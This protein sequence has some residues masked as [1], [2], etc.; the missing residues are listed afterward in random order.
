MYHS[1]EWWQISG[2]FMVT[3]GVDRYTGEI[4]MTDQEKIC[5]LTDLFTQLLLAHMADHATKDEKLI[6]AIYKKIEEI[7]GKK[8]NETKIPESKQELFDCGLCRVDR[9][10]WV[11]VKVLP[12]NEVIIDNE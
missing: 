6:E 4:C 9:M 2:N 5:A 7:S 8:E 12:N 10:D 11:R 3:S 1:P